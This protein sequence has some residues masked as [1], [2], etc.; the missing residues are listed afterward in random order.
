MVKLLIEHN[1]DV[2]I[3]NSFAKE[4]RMIIFAYPFNSFK[5]LHYAVRLKRKDLVKVVIDLY[6]CNR[7]D[8]SACW[9]RYQN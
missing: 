1:A 3:G 5:A 6:L 7:I 4:T 9:C 8:S 2:N